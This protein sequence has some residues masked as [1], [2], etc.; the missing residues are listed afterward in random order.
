[1]IRPMRSTKQRMVGYIVAC[2][3]RIRRVSVVLFGED[4]IV[5]Y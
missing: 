1:M 4:V 2:L 3:Q 5:F